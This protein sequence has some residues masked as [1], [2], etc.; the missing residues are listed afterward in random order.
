MLIHIIALPTLK[1]FNELLHTLQNYP[2]PLSKSLIPFLFALLG[3]AESLKDASRAQIQALYAT[4][5]LSTLPKGKSLVEG[6]KLANEELVAS[7]NRLYEADSSF[8]KTQ[9]SSLEAETLTA[10]AEFVSSQWETVTE[11]NLVSHTYT[12]GSETH[13]F[14]SGS[15]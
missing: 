1:T 8:S 4:R 10:Y 15:I 14:C 6:L 11:T 5:H 7:C 2:T 3:E 12:F 9:S 13:S